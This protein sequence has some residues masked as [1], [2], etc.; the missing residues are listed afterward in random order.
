MLSLRL[1]EYSAAAGYSKGK[2]KIRQ[3]GK[4]R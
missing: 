4:Q 1:I 3:K 2:G